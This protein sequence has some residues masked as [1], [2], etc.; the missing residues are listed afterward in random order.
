MK[1]LSDE[2]ASHH[3]DTA[4]E[5][6]AYLRELQQLKPDYRSHKIDGDLEQLSRIDYTQAMMTSLL[7]QIKRDRA[8]NLG[9]RKETNKMSQTVLKDYEAEMTQI[10]TYQGLIAARKQMEQECLSAAKLFVLCRDR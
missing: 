5:E 10:Q 3:F 8:L 4:K 6:K 7:E 2:L 9:F 1:P